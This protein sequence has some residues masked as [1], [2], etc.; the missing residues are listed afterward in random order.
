[1]KTKEPGEDMHRNSK[2]IGRRHSFVGGF[3]LL[4]LFSVFLVGCGGSDGEMAE[5]VETPEEQ[6][7]AVT[8]GPVD[9][10]DLAPTD[11]GRVAVGMEAP[12]FSLA[13]IA[14]GTLTLSSLRESKDVIL[15]FYRGHW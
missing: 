6:E 8:L 4:G 15:V 10:F 3:F 7:Q 1:M 5:E 12:D 2:L 13:T 11:I 14:G 9:G